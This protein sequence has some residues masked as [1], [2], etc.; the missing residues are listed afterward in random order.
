MIFWKRK[1][2]IVQPRRVSSTQLELEIAKQIF[3]E[4]FHARPDDVEKMIHS[5][6]EERDWHEERKDGLWPAEFCL[7]E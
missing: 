2:S 7:G 5:R 1:A 3:Q 4:V 6:L